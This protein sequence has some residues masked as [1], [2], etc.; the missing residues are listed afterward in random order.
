VSVGWYAYAAALIGIAFI[1]AGYLRGVRQ[2]TPLEWFALGTAVLATA[3][4]ATYSAFFYH[5]PDFPAPW[6]AIA[7]G[8]AAQSLACLI[9]GSAKPA[10]TARRVVAGV[11]AV[12]VLVV[13]GIE[14]R[15]LEPRQ[16]PASPASAAALIPPGSCVVA[17]Q[18]S[19]LI[20]ANRFT[21]P[22]SGCPDVVDALATTLSLS[23]GVSPQGGAGDSAKVVGD[24]EAMFAKA[25]YAWIS[26]GAS[27]ITN[28]AADRIPWTPAFEAW[29]AA[30]FRVIATYQGYGESTLYARDH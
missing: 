9:K 3:A 6:I 4:I 20:A 13:A 14:A 22:S 23:G 7:V 10:R 15:E 16:M 30:H 19:Y 27:A 1:A 26:G 18:V 2:R 5:Y 12:A 25:Q 29:F 24:W 28:S 8:A 17:D 21:A 11:V